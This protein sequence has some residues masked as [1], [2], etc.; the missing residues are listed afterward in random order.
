MTIKKSALY[1][2]RESGK[3]VLAFYLIYLLVLVVLTVTVTAVTLSWLGVGGDVNLSGSTGT[4]SG[5]F[6]FVLGLCTFKENFLMLQQN[7]V[8]RRSLFLGRLLASAALCLAMAALDT[9][10]FHLITLIPMWEGANMFGLLYPQTGVG[11]VLAQIGL[12]FAANMALYFLGYCITALYYR[13]NT[14]LKVVVSITVPLLL[15]GPLSLVDYALFG[16]R[17]TLAV[18]RFTVAAMGIGRG[19][20]WMGVLTLVVVAALFSLFAWLLIRKAPVK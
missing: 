14:A 15:F 12:F 8:S 19:M 2:L 20:P 13:M 3:S 18:Q 16:G 1:Q 17:V 9:V 11:A 6:L 5:I 4:A 7:G 10:V